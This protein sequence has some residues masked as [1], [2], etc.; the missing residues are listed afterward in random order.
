MASKKLKSIEIAASKPFNEHRKGMFICAG[1]AAAP[2]TVDTRRRDIRA[3]KGAGSY[4]R[5]ERFGRDY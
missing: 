4:S 2:I 5:R 3:R 1:N